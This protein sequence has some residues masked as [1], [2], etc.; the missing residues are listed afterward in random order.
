MKQMWIIFL[1][2]S[3][4]ACRVNQ[5]EQQ[6]ASPQVEADLVRWVAYQP[7]Q[8]TLISAHRGGKGYPGYP[9]N[10]LET[11]QYVQEQIPNA[12][13]EV[14]VAQTQD[15]QLVL[16]HDD[17]LDR[18]TNGNGPIQQHTLAELSEL[19]LTDDEKELTAY[20]IPTLEAVLDWAKET[21]ALL[22]VDIKRSVDPLVVWEFI[23]QADAQHQ[24][25]MITYSLA[26][27]Q[28]LYKYDPGVVMSVSMRNQEEVER[29]LN[30]GIPRQNMI[31]FTGTRKSPP[32][33]F[34]DLHAA[35][36]RCIFGT[37][38]NL[39]RSREARD[40]SLYR[41][42]EQDGV[43]IFAT[44]RPLEVAKALGL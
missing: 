31:A 32:S 41:S 28:K 43:D 40:G 14:D 36:I 27:A 24:C 25:I 22:T 13:F 6:S 33:L 39:D 16:M 44:D 37:L 10:C 34:A 38:G 19:L 2:L 30:S 23:R 15:G 20:R 4:G 29:A 8:G 21:K 1:A 9:E 5:Q 11:M 12:V 7:G 42:L 35:G 3:I 18:T 17:Q 26:T